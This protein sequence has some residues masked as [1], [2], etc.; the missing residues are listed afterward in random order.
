MARRIAPARFMRATLVASVSGMRP[1]KIGEPRWVSTP[2]VSN[3]SLTVNG[4]PWSGPTFPPAA[5]SSSAALAASSAPSASVTMALMLGL[6]ASMRSRCA[7]TT[8]TDEAFPV[9]ISSAS[10]VASV[11]MR[12]V[13]MTESLP[14]R[15]L[16]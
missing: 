14:G 2:A 10:P 15:L 11:W 12:S 6:V 3:E 5:S 7:C 9:R 4:T 1:S 13:V 16:F 8:S